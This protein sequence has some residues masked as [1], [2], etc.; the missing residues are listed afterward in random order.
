MSGT[1]L[2][3]WTKKVTL[4]P[5]NEV[6]FKISDDHKTEYK[7]ADATITIINK[8]QSA[9]LFKVK[10]TNIKNYMVRPNS[11]IIPPGHSVNVKILT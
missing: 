1:P 11:E 3:D 9:V 8:S 5:P 4:S 6:K 10:T 2:E 7:R